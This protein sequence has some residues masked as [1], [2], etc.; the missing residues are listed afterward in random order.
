MVDVKSTLRHGGDHFFNLVP[1]A[2]VLDEVAE[3]LD[4][5]EQIA[6]VDPHVVKI[7]FPLDL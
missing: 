6:L 5:E 3:L 4:G 2:M 1:A 7:S